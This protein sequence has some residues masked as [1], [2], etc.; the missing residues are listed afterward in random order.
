MPQFTN[1]DIGALSDRIA[2]IPNLKDVV[3]NGHR[4]RVLQETVSMER[5]V[6]ISLWHN[7]D[8]NE[9]QVTHAIEILQ[10]IKA[11][12]EHLS[13]KQAKVT[14]GTLLHVCPGGALP[15]SVIMP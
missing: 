13:Q 9:K 8:Q 5:H 12:A 11:T 2:H 1:W 3:L 4:W 6:D 7:M 14:Q 15:R 10:C